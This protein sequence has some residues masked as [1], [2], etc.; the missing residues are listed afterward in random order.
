MTQLQFLR[1]EAVAHLLERASTS[2]SVPVSIHFVDG[3]TEGQ[4]IAGHGNCAMCAYL[5]ELPAGRKACRAS[6]TKA[7]TSALRRNRPALF[8]CHMG[9]GCAAVPVFDDAGE[10]ATP[11]KNKGFVLTIGPYSPSEIPNA[12]EFDARRR[13]A[14]LGWDEPE[15]PAPLDDIHGMTSTAA[16]ALALWLMEMLADLWARDQE[17]DVDV[18]DAASL[19]K[20]RRSPRK[21][22]PLD[23]YQANDIVVAVQAGDYRHVKSIVL[24]VLAEGGE[25]K[26]AAVRPG[27]STALMAAV[28]EGME[29]AGIDTTSHRMNL[30]NLNMSDSGTN[31]AQQMAMQ[32]MRLLSPFVR[33]A[34]R[35]NDKDAVLSDLNALVLERLADGLSLKEAGQ[36][37]EVHPSTISHK[38]QRRYSLSYS[39]YVARLR[40]DKAKDLL[41]RTE[42]SIIEIARRVGIGDASN[43][44]KLFKRYEHMTPLQYRERMDILS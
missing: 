39:Q 3:D 27:R 40:V 18:S 17:E 33:D 41:Q 20:T 21:L 4:R 14:E 16:P 23:P 36:T 29:A 12:L 43:L 2:C 10:I 5:N 24:T 34:R 28:I 32:I 15:L 30:A 37:L 38:L 42:L 35:K 7:A 22:P 25:T 9:F 6:R 13:L 44:N 8:V 31:P 26:C 1:D 19:K 11:E